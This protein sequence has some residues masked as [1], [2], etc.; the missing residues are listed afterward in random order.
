MKYVSIDIETTGKNPELDQ[1]LSFGA[2]IE[3]TDK[4]LDFEN[5]P[6]FHC[7]IPHSRLTGDVYAL[8]MN[9]KIIEKIKN[10]HKCNSN[11]YD[12]FINFEKVCDAFY[13]FLFLNAYKCGM[14]LDLAIKTKEV[15]SIRIPDT[16]YNSPKIN[17]NVAGKNFMGFDYLFLKK[18][19]NWNSYFEI[20]KREI[21]P[22]ILYVDW[23]T[24][25]T[26]PDLKTCKE[27]NDDNSIV[28]HDALKDAWDVI[29]LLRRFY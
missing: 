1:I 13:D 22:S 2:I 3:D 11:E 15:N 16:F 24:D 10:Y 29:T 9:S 4:K 20:N 25:S 21:D 17:F 8:S 28:E 5:I 26:L 19:P 12:S 6:K 14:R 27:R 18:L 7:Y 23:S